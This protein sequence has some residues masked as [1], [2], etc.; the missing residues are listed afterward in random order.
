MSKLICGCCGS[1]TSWD[2]SYG[3]EEFLLCSHCVNSFL[4]E[5]ISVSEFLP[6]IFHL[7]EI[8]QEKNKKEK[9]K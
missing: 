4:S 7:G 2:S 3:Y 8:R 5:N 9:E 1:R 6:V